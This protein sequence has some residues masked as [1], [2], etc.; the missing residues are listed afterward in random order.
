MLSMVTEQLITTLVGMTATGV[1]GFLVARLKVLS[2]FDNARI[3]IDKA[4]ARNLIFEACEKY[5]IRGEKL[6]IARYDE[7]L[8]IFDAYTTLGGNGTAKKYMEEIKA[9]RPYLVID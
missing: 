3:E 4:V 5:V 8:R 9:L 7:L 6:T 1:I 2:K